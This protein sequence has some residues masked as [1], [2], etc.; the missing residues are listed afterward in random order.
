MEKA[1]LCLASAL[2]LA[3]SAKVLKNPAE[4]EG[5]FAA[6]SGTAFM[7]DFNR[8][9][10]NT[11]TGSAGTVQAG[12]F[13]PALFGSGVRMQ[14]GAAG[15]YLIDFP[16]T[17]E[18][19]LRS[20]TEGSLEGLIWTDS[21]Q[22]GFAHVIEK[23]WQYSLSIHD[24]KLA[25][26]FGTVWWYSQVSIPTGKWSYVAATFDGH[27]LSLYL[28]GV[29][30]ESA[31]YTGERGSGYSTEYDL[32]LGNSSTSAY[33]IP[34]KGIIDAARVSRVVRTPAEIA[35]VWAGIAKKIR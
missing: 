29:W 13:T 12:L 20:G 3:C 7:A 11:V 32:A 10:V 34:F 26:S 18:L 19:S 9:S 21:T 4:P 17:E 2:L 1:L 8:V 28:N 16:N 30:A 27:T 24:G 14:V 5:P 33:N 15:K 6:D 22:P 35:A 25:A 31:P 23:A